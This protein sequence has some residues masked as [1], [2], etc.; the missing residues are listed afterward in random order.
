MKEQKDAEKMKVFYGWG[1]IKSSILT[2]F[3]THSSFSSNHH[4]Y[5]RIKLQPPTQT[6][7][8]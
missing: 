7:N 6:S 8:L 3:N 2:L 4:T 1:L 5:H